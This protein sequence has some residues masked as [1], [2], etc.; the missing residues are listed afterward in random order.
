MDNT[1]KLERSSRRLEAGYQIAVETG[2]CSLMD[3]RR[4]ETELGGRGFKIVVRMSEQQQ[5][6]LL[7]CAVGVC[8]FVLCVYLEGW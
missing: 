2:T 4:G 1:E 6:V 7:I 3:W 5:I 8:V